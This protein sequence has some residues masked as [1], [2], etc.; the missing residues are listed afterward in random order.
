M[1]A[2]DAGNSGASLGDL[3]RHTRANHAS[4]SDSKP[5]KAQALVDEMQQEQEASENAP[6]G[7]KNYDAGD[8]RLFVPFPYSLEG[9]DNGGAVLLGSRLGITNTEVVAGNPIPVPADA[10]ED[11]L[12]N[13]VRQYAGQRGPQAYCSAIKQGAHK[14]FRCA[15][16]GNPSLLG[17]VVWGSMEFIVASN[18]LIPVMCV[19]PDAMQSCLVYDNWGHNTCSDR[20]A[21]KTQAAIEASNRE[22][23]TTFQM[24]DQVIYPS[25]TLKEDIV[26][27]PAKIAE[28]SDQPNPQSKAL[29]PTAV[30]WA[31]PVQAH[32]P[33]D[34]G[35]QSPSLA[36]LARQTRQ[37]P[38]GPPLAKLDSAE[39]TSVAPA[40][41]Q[42]FVLQYCINPQQ[43][44][45]ATVVIPEKAEVVSRV[46]RF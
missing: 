32:E 34:S 12:M 3:A 43:C 26:V 11:T 42:S 36:E 16:Q 4:T 25:I 17:H 18:S 10:R 27:H 45:A 40:G 23:T 13:V 29:Q 39:G 15:W 35:S 41:F 7:F 33:G 19:S 14:A 46:Q 22:E 1:P 8:Y 5:S 28:K 9:R 2:Q 21:Y 31:P 30:G 24:C 38:H 44:G 37:A 6:V 20:N